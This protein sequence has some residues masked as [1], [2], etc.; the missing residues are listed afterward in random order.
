VIPQAEGPARLVKAM[1]RLYGGLEAIGADEQTRWDVLGRVAR[2]CVPAARTPIMRTLL[3]DGGRMRTAAVAED[4]DMVTKT[5]HRYLDDLALLRIVKRSKGG[6]ADN[7]PDMWAATDW[8][9]ESWPTKVGLTY[10]SLR[11]E[12][13]EEGTANDGHDDDEQA[14]PRTSQ[15]H[16]EPPLWPEAAAREDDGPPA[17]SALWLAQHPDA[18]TA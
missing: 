9:R 1:R 18:E 11:E 5:C 16:S 6:A 8:L 4:V 17:R 13:S 10:T 15:S 2:D 14:H 3:A 12:E 7:S